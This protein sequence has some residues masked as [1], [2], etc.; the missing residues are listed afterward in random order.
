MRRRAFI[1]LI[2]GA[3]AGLALWPLAARAQQSAMPVIGFLHQGPPEPFALTNA[4]RQGLSEGGSID[5]RSVTIENRW[6]EGQYDRLPALAA[7]LVSHRVAVIAANFLPAALA[8]KAATQTIPIVFLT[9]SDPISAGLVSSINRPTGNVTGIAFMFTLLGAKNLQLLRELV[10]NATVIAVL[11]N[12]S[13]PNAEPQLRDV[14]AAAHALGQQLVVLDATTEREIDSV[15]ATLAERQVGALLVTADGFLIGQQD[16]LV[17]LAARYAVPTMYPLSQYVTAGGLISYGASLSD[18]FRQTG[19]YVGRIL[20]GT[21]PADLPVLQSA[22][23]E[24][25]INLKTA[26]ALG[27]EISPKLLA[28][29]DEVIE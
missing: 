28:L 14:Q 18:A 7:D 21:H 2:G 9:G 29:A 4:F 6:A 8:A 15:F 3:A 25:V 20:K 26:K 22:K 17:A 19:I 5:G 12:P 16:Q 10:P 24:L 27:L 13:N 1:V 23:F 11:V